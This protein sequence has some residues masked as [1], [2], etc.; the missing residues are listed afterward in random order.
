MMQLAEAL[1]H[2]AAQAAYG[3]DIN[4][5]SSL[6]VWAVSTDV[7]YRFSKVG[8]VLGRLVDY[9]RPLFLPVG[10]YIILDAVQVADYDAKLLLPWVDLR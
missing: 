4:G 8:C 9:L 3:D 5:T 10:S 1:V 6:G 7:F 2:A